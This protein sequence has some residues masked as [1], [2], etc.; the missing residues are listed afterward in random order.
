MNP[1]DASPSPQHPVRTLLSW[2][3]GK[4][5]AW[6]YHL[7]RA[8]PQVE[9]VGLLTTVNTQFDRVAMHGTSRGLLEAQASALGIPLWEV[10]IPFPCS[11]VQYEEA[12]G[13]VMQQALAAGVE[14]VAFGDLF[15]ED[16]RAYREEKMS[17]TG[18]RAVFPL[19]GEP[20]GELARRM[21]TSGLRSVI[22]CVNP[23]MLDGSFA[24]RVWDSDL[25]SE[26]PESVDPCGEHGEFHTAVVASP[27]F[28]NSL[29]YRV[30]ETVRR[31]GFVFTEVTVIR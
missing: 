23:E 28:P 31:D 13:Q 22:T 1:A 27:D 7:L 15:L 18:M 21:T 3:S 16:V 4:D 11:N 20:T 10:P 24:G 17:A 14:Q 5:S 8:D 2:S 9:V 19:W 29:S 12:M 6:T 26:L 25:L 30:G